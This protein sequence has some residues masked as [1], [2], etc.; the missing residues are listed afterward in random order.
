MRK[1]LYINTGSEIKNAESTKNNSS[2]FLSIINN[3]SLTT[4]DSAT[5]FSSPFNTIVAH[6]NRSKI[7]KTKPF[8]KSKSNKKY[9][10]L[11][12][13]TGYNNRNSKYNNIFL[14]KINTTTQTFELFNN[15]DQILKDRKRHY[16]GRTLKQTKS[17]ILQKSKEICLNNFM[18]TQLREKR[19]EINNKQIKIFSQLNLSEKRFEY[20][21]KNFIDFVEGINRKE[22]EE[23]RNLNNLKNVSKNVEMD[24]LEEMSVN[25]N[26]ESKIEHYI[27]QIILL[28]AYGSFLH[29][30]F[31]RPFTLDEIKKINLKGKKFIY[32]SNI[33]L[34]LFDE[35]L[36]N[37]E[38]NLDIISDVEQLMD[39][40]TYFEE[41]VVKIIREKEELE[42]SIKEA[43]NNY[44]IIL[45]QLK[46]RINNNE[47]EYIKLK[48]DKKELN[49]IMEDNINYDIK[50]TNEIENYV[51][52]INEF[53]K[54]IGINLNKNQKISKTN[55]IL[56]SSYICEQ[57]INF[58]GEK[59]RL[60]NENI[61]NIE[62]IINNGDE[63]DKELIESLI[64]ERKKLNKKEK[65]M[66][67]LKLQKLEENKKRL[68]AVE[69]AKK[70]VIRGRKVF[71]DIPVFL[72][73]NK[74]IKIIKD[75]KYEDFEYLNYSSDKE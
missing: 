55:D 69:K 11:N 58:L 39:K 3:R 27:K 41:K 53:A 23:E 63:K 14:P 71:P 25:K 42:Q 4:N 40:F 65:Q 35:S 19:D 12:I 57:I 31:Y 18:I 7:L 70:V 21:Y 45:E 9:S 29:R 8:A 6:T 5:A 30:V 32:L 13:F 28:Q 16:M 72:N 50:K 44:N 46:D 61:K 66:I 54:E 67:V 47:K 10:P 64:Y 59:E 24:L 2:N 38:E 1:N 73:K 48:K 15:A 52:Y 33:I 36:K 37:Y 43:N 56:E 51:E 34:S 22:K 26:I 62:D 20:D 17:S 75:D 74:K 49:N 68:K 60:I